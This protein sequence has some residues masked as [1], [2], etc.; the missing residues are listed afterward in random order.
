MDDN[1]LCNSNPW[2]YHLYSK[3][4]NALSKHIWN[5]LINLETPLIGTHIE[6]NFPWTK[7]IISTTIVKTVSAMD[8]ENDVI[9]LGLPLAVFR[10]K[11]FV[12]L[13][14]FMNKINTFKMITKIRKIKILCK[15]LFFEKPCLQYLQTIWSSPLWTGDKMVIPI[16]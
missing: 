13:N 7:N 14:I 15:Y 11:K 6:N 2:L 10:G 9:I 16:V 5:T 8:T 12:K 3:Q 1:L 4:Y